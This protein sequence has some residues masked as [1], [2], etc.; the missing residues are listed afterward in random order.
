MVDTLRHIGVERFTDIDL[1]VGDQRW[2]TTE[3]PQRYKDWNEPIADG[4]FLI[5]QSTTEQKFMQLKAINIKLNLDLKIEIGENLETDDAMAR[6]NKAGGGKKNSRLAVMFP[7]GYVMRGTSIQD[8]FQLC[9]KRMGID[10]IKRKNIQWA[11]KPLVTVTQ[12]YRS[13]MEIDNH[14]WLYLPGSF[15]DCTKLLRVMSAMLGVGLKVGTAEEFVPKNSIIGDS[16]TSQSESATSSD[17][18]TSTPDGK[19]KKKSE[20]VQLSLFDD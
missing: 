8:T 12:Q 20:P 2:V 9:A 5:T 10:L 7:D 15:K 1:M 19:Q 14:T 16:K 6:T 3:V 18:E 11:G 17:V 4:W 13:Q